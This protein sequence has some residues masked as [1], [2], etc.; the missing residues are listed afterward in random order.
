MQNDREKNI[1]CIYTSKHIANE[2]QWDLSSVIGII[3][4]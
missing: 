1:D 2:I 4:D 3:K